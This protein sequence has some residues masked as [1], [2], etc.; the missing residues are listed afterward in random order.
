MKPVSDIPL[1]IILVLSPSEILRI[2]VEKTK[3]IVNNI[4]PILKGKG[5]TYIDSINGIN[6]I[7]YLS[8]K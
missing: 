2:S 4:I 3:P 7:K 8:L 6:S 1:N 5:T